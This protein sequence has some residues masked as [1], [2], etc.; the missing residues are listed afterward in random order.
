VF[1]QPGAAEQLR[2]VKYIWQ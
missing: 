1:H 2:V